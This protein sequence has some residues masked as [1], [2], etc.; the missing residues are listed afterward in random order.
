MKFSGLRNLISARRTK[1]A[2]KIPGKRKFSNTVSTWAYDIPEGRL[3]LRGWAGA[4]APTS[5]KVVNTTTGAEATVQT[6]FSRPD[7][8]KLF[9]SEKEDGYG[10]HYSAPFSW[11]PG[12]YIEVRAKTDQGHCASAVLIGPETPL[13]A[14]VTVE[15]CYF[16]DHC[17]CVWARGRVVANVYPPLAVELKLDS[18]VAVTVDVGAIRLDKGHVGVNW[19][20]D[21][22]TECQPELA[23]VTVSFAGGKTAQTTTRV[24][25]EP[26]HHETKPEEKSLYAWACTGGQLPSIDIIEPSLTYFGPEPMHNRQPVLIIVHN[27]FAPER[28]EKRRALEGLR[29]AL[30]DRGSEL[31]ILHHG[32]GDA[33]CNVPQVNFFDGAL[34]NHSGAGIPTVSTE[35]LDHCDRLLYGFHTQI[36]LRPKSLKYCQDTVRDQQKRLRAA[37]SMICPSSVLLWHQWNSLMVLGRAL[38]ESAGIQSFFVHEGVLP[39]TMTVDAQGMMAE[40]ECT[41]VRLKQTP[42]N[43]A[44]FEAARRAINEVSNRG[45]DRKPQIDSP[46]T[47]DLLERLKREGK[48]IIFYAGSND[49]Q[50]GV[51]PLDDPNTTLHSGG[52]GDSGGALAAL[53]K[54][55]AQMNAIVVHKPHPNLRPMRTELEA[56]NLFEVFGGKSVE[57]VRMSDVTATLVSSLSYISAAHEKPTLVMGA[58]SLSGSGAVFEARN[59]GSLEKAL[60]A[61]LLDTGRA[62]RKAR[63]EEHVAALLH[64]HLYQYGDKTDFAQLGYTHA[65]DRI[66]GLE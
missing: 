50:S 33:G 22:A 13:D 23:Q 38:C 4:P 17:G 51:L 35:V 6:G 61:A 32:N 37:L 2:G 49:W 36:D 43:M 56:E 59:D 58:N 26:R 57:L 15:S 60:E 28:P 45:L 7:V 1:R 65:A 3:D 9:E 19:S 30:L 66:L 64:G 62:E 25:S 46:A 34:C 41:G 42:K 12:E 55:A 47:I 20:I 40:A 27:L 53:V 39:G 11:L 63:L 14:K 18:E 48:K 8:A 10:Y 21:I 52:Y 54:T 24:G 31:V 5:V 44:V 29:Q 16:D